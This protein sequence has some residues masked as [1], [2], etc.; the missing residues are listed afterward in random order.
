[1]S[2]MKAEMSLASLDGMVNIKITLRSLMRIMSMM[3]IDKH[4]DDNDFDED[5]DDAQ[6]DLMMIRMMMMLRRMTI[7]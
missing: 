5:E 4:D 1:M 6:E 3:I 2:T 7:Q